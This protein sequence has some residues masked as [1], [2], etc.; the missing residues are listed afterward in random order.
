MSLTK[1]QRPRL[2]V[3]GRMQGGKTAFLFTLSSPQRKVLEDVGR[4][5]FAEARL[6]A[7][8]FCCLA[9]FLLVTCLCHV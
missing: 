5:L 9:V 7:C 8:C 3:K 4:R 6:L 1:E 2:E